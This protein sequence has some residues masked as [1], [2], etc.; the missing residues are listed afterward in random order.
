MSAVVGLHRG[1][2]SDC[3]LDGAGEGT[4]GPDLVEVTAGREDRSGEVRDRDDA[5][6]TSVG[7]GLSNCWE[8][9]TGLLSKVQAACRRSGRLG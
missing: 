9:G 2:G 4:G 6:G 7:A 1:P 3:L 5:L 8:V